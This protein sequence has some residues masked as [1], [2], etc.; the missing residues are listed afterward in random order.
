MILRYIQAT[1][2]EFFGNFS[3]VHTHILVCL[4]YIYLFNAYRIK[5]V[6]SVTGIKNVAFNVFAHDTPYSMIYFF[7]IY[8]EAIV[9]VLALAFAFVLAFALV[10]KL[11]TII[12]NAFQF[13]K[14]LI[15]FF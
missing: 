10:L 7:Y 5:P 12:Q 2:L 13:V 14:H 11:G 1:L 6:L 4:Y 15:D 8:C 3:L 9:L